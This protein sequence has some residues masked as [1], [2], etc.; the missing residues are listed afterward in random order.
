M[1]MLKNPLTYF[2]AQQEVDRV[3]G[4]ERIIAKH[5]NQL[6]YIDAVLKETL[7]LRPVAPVIQRGV[8]PENT[9]KVNTLGGKYVIPEDYP[10][11]CL[12]SKIQ[13]DPK[14]WGEDA[15]EF[16]P[17]RMFGEKFDNLPKNAW[18]VSQT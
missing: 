2:A 1:Y 12:L 4:K 14:V 10:I 5:L 11:G 6:Q 18:K 13:T 9:A 17:G 8:R 16:N 3:I 7:R 15:E